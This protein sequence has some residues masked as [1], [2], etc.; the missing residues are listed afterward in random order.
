MDFEPY[1]IENLL[2]V[3]G[4]D[5]SFVLEILGMFVQTLKTEEIEIKAALEEK[6]WSTVQ[7]IAHRLRSSAGSVGAKNVYA[8]CKELE[9]YIKSG[10]I[11]EE[12]IFLLAEN[13]FASCI[14]D[15]SEIEK[16]LTKL[17]QNS[18]D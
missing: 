10:E 12:E 2:E 18:F 15:F 11:K 16:E 17:G 3:S 6:N 14:F 7:F 9:Q 4:N 13:L 1:N 5:T 8:S